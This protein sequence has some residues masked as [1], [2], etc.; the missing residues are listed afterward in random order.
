MGIFDEKRREMEEARTMEA[1]TL[2]IGP[3]DMENPRVVELLERI[4]HGRKMKNKGMIVGDLR[5]DDVQELMGILK[6][7]K[8]E[9]LAE[10]VERY[11]GKPE[12]HVLRAPL[13]WQ[14]SGEAA[15]A[16]LDGIA[17][18]EM[19]FAAGGATPEA[20]SCAEHFNQICGMVVRM[21]DEL[22]DKFPWLKEE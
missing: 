9:R 3:R 16:I 13:E 4:N 17:K 20:A 2:R 14:K 6:D 7:M 19:R 15:M 1:R 22:R 8:E 18:H 5:D 11:K 21:C 12:E 10:K